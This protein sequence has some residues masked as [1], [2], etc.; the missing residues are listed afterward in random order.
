L[1]EAIR[2][3]LSLLLGLLPRLERVEEWLRLCLLL[4]V[5]RLELLL[6]HPK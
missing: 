4:L 1:K 6:G 5:L 2:R 3:L